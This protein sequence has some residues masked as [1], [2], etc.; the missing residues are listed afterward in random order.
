M[1]S[2]GYYGFR[3]GKS[4]TSNIIRET[5]NLIWK[6]MQ[7]V[8]PNPSKAMW[9]DIALSFGNR[10]GFPNCLGAI[11]GKHVI[12][13]VLKFSLLFY[14]IYNNVNKFISIKAFPNHNSLTFNYKHSH[15]IV[16]MAV[17]DADYKFILVDIGALGHNSDGGV[18]RNSRFGKA[19]LDNTE[20]LQLPPPKN[21]PGTNKVAPFVFVGDEAFPLR[22]NLMRPYPGRNIKIL[23]P[24]QDNFNRRLSRARRVV[25]NSFGILASRFR[26]Y[27]K[28]IIASQETT[29]NIVKATVCLHNFLRDRSSSKYIQA[30]LLDRETSEGFVI[31]G[32]W[33][34]EDN[35]GLRSILRTGSNRASN[36]A[37]SVRNIYT[38]FFTQMH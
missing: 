10:W 37:I 32:Q 19:I 15:S 31:S 35:Q 29:I 18:F 22:P 4:T 16:L 20:D 28:P 27:R 13:Q 25:E 7:F 30:E 17:A 34:E 5:T 23:P 2:V 6:K 11:D 14:N 8:F 9:E 38:D 1:K 33:R 21:L 26:V 12:I 36:G 24:E 3:I